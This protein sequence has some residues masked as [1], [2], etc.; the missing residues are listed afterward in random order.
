MPAGFDVPEYAPFPDPC[1]SANSQL[2][3]GLGFC[4]ETMLGNCEFFVP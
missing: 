1:Q 2:L 3:D 4:A